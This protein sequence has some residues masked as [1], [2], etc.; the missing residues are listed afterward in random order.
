[1]GDLKKKFLQMHMHKK[2]ILAYDNPANPVG[3]KKNSS[4]MFPELT[5]ET[6]S[7][8]RLLKI[9]ASGQR[10]IAQY[11]VRLRYLYLYIESNCGFQS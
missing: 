2:K 3:W 11:C 10:F 7:I 1:M 9:I 4:K 8:S 5:H 6:L